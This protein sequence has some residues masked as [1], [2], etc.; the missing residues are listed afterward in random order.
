MK[1]LG[2]KR[3]ISKPKTNPHKKIAR[4]EMDSK[5]NKLYKQVAASDGEDKWSSLQSKECVSSDNTSPASCTPLSCHGDR[6]IDSGCWKVTDRAVECM[7]Q[8]LNHRRTS[9][10]W[11]EGSSNTPKPYPQILT[12]TLHRL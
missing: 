2:H 6:L 10:G 5:Q 9:F 3:V 7:N 12:R 11:T 8:Q 1:G 4:D